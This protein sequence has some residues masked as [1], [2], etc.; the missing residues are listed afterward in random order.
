MI[1]TLVLGL[2]SAGSSKT[3]TLPSKCPLNVFTWARYSVRKPFQAPNALPFFLD[4]SQNKRRL[5][6]LAFG[7][8][9][10][11]ADGTRPWR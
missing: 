5:S 3:M 6:H 10:F 4:L 8:F 9:Y 2:K 1:L 11:E 7:I